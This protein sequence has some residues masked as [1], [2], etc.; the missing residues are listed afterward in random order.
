MKFNRRKVAVA[1]AIAC[2][3]MGTTVY[4]TAQLLYQL[5]FR[6]SRGPDL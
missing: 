6:Q 4:A 5:R 2:I 3:A 1:A